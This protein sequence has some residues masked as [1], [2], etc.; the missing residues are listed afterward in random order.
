[1]SLKSIKTQF[2]IFLICFAL[3][4][5][6]IEHDALFLLSAF[7]AC[8]SAMLLDSMIIFFK[9]KKLRLTDSSVITGL[10]IGFV[11]SGYQPLRVLALASVFAI[12]SKHIIRINK[13]HLFNPA[14]CGIFLTI[15]FFHAFTQWRGANFWYILIFLGAYF[16]YKVRKLEIFVSYT[17][18]FLILFVIQGIVQKTQLDIFSFLN[19]FFIFIMLIEPKTTPIKLVGKIIF[20]TG[21]AILVFVLMAFEVRFDAFI[22]SLLVLNLFVPLLNRSPV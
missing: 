12:A 4:V 11:L 22:P 21:V 20:G 13:K 14:A 6:A 15:L 9:E 16:T 7:V 19:Y 17:L 10:I 18:T 8:L 1:M 3:F 5:S 2:I